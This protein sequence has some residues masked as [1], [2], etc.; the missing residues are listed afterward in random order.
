MK[1]ERASQFF[2]FVAGEIGHHHRD[3]EHLFLK[4][5]NT[6]CAFQN[7]LEQRFEIAMKIGDLFRARRVAP[8][9]DAPYLP[10]SD[11]AE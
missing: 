3:F 4:Q 9:M 2:R 5:R 1:A 6:E 8:D 7:R 11:R 10:E